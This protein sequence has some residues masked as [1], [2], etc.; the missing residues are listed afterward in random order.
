MVND[1]NFLS[2]T[3]V[4]LKVERLGGLGDG[5]AAHE[6]RRV[7][8][9][10]SAAGDTLE[11][12]LRDTGA[13]A[14]HGDILSLRSPGPDRTDAPCPHYAAC[15]SCTLQHLREEAYRAFKRHTLREAVRKSGYILPAEPT[16]Y[17][18]PH[19][20]RRRADF[21]IVRTASGRAPGYLLLKSHDATPINSCLILTPALQTYLP[22]LTHALIAHENIPLAGIQITQL[23]HGID[24]V[25]R[26]PEDA[27]YDAVEMQRFADDLK[28]SRISIHDEHTPRVL[29]RYTPATVSVGTHEIP[30]PPGA[31]LQASQ[32]GQD[33]LIRL[34]LQGVQ[35][36]GPV[37]DLFSGIGTYSVPLAAAGAKVHAVEVSPSMTAGLSAFAKNVGLPITAE[38]RDLFRNALSADA[39]NRY[40]A[41]VINPP[42]AGAKLQCERLAQSRVKRIVM[43][44][45][46]PAT[47]ARDAAIL[48][49]GGYRLDSAEGIDQFV[50]SA[51]LEIVA[52]FSR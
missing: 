21:K 46:N 13:E 8:I 3:P 51:H 38:R 6:N 39:L 35:N 12:M 15:G 29:R 37:L 41:A 22:T 18:L 4:T 31:F 44:S 20:T 17:F 49:A 42:R 25:L 10:K 16:V 5:I 34:V 47:F 43:V 30:L 48:R 28:A 1:Y 26:F 7:L 50:W 45:C 2:S 9:P 32:E 11:I 14:L 27:T 52:V 33:T 23:K 19:A 40:S 36:S 24:A